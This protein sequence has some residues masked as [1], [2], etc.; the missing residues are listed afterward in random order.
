MMSEWHAWRRR[1]AGG[2]YTNK[3][4]YRMVAATPSSSGVSHELHELS[5][6]YFYYTAPIHYS[7]V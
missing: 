7:T 2:A 1:A 5:K 6:E 3:Y 4:R